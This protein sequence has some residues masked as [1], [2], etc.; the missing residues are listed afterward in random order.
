MIKIIAIILLTLIAEP[1]VAQN[2]VSYPKDTSFSKSELN[3]EVLW[4]TFED[5]YAFFTLRNI[6]WHKSYQ[7][8]RPLVK[9]SISD[10]SLFAIF[11]KMLAPFQ[12]NHINVIV[13]GVKQF[14][15]IKP[16]QFAR[17]FPTDSSRN[18]F[19]QMVDYS[20]LRKHFAP[21]QYAGLRNNGIPLFAYSTSGK[22][23]YLRFNRCFVDGD[24]ESIP[25]AMAAGKI[26]D[27]VF[28]NF[29][30]AESLIVD[31]RDNMGGNDEFSF[32][33]AARFTNVKLAAMFKQSRTRGGKYEDFENIQTWYLEPKGQRKFTK[34]VVVLT[35]D[36]T[37]SAGD[38]FALVMKELPNVKIIGTNTRGIYSDMYGFTLPNGW[39]VSLSNQRYYNSK[40]VCY[41]GSGTPV[42][43]HSVNTNR[44]LKK[45]NDP[46][47]E[48]AI[49]TLSRKR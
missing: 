11:S 26:L 43:I 23:G 44:D 22:L 1:V 37:V 16:S 12:D 49:K 10:D 35:N 3:F 34:P 29:Q 21:M 31:V 41:E 47:L 40:M 6:D 19:W 24:A 4:H 17:E 14:K 46:V 38:V 28:A 7:M 48:V 5:N 32:E 27:S 15:S 13:P 25:D 36:K 8:Y 18:M 30:H 45:M 33:V 39:L 20:L 2:P 42:D 9:A